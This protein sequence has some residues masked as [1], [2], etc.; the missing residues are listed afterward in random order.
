MTACGRNALHVVATA[1]ASIGDRIRLSPLRA[2]QTE[3]LVDAE[4][5]IL[6]RVAWLPPV[7]EDPEVQTPDVTELVSLDL[8]P[9][10]DPAQFAP[11][12]GSVV[13]ESW[14]E[15]L[16]AGG[17][18]MA[19]AKTTAGL[20]AG[21]LGALIRYW[22]LGRARPDP[23]DPEVAMPTDDPAPEMTAE[24]RPAG[25]E[26]SDEVL[27][28]L[29]DSG[30][31]AFDATLH[32]WYDVPAMLSQVPEPARQTGFGGLGMLLN[33]LTEYGAAAAHSVSALRVG[34]P[35]RYQ[36]DHRHEVKRGP[37]TIACDG[38]RRWRVYDDKMTVGPAEPPPSDI[39][40]VADA[41]WL[42]ECQIAGGALIMAG[43]RPA[44]RMD[45]A[46]GDAPWSFLMMFP[47][48]VAVVDA[49]LGVILSLTSYLGGKA[50]RR[51]ELRDVAATGAEDFRVNVPSDLRTEP[52]T[53]R[54]ASV[55]DAD[56]RH[57]GVTPLKVAGVV[58]REVGKE[59]AKAARSF[60]RR[61]GPP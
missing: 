19:V 56:P 26:V 21:G 33:A 57:Q 24:G 36:I 38:Q 52:E 8:D 46:R 11:P 28:V 37:K 29:H 15:S 13:G 22:P 5:G 31:S 40:D 58:A 61:L 10:I 59:A 60:L 14:S 23:G 27:Q 41:S 44:Y 43:D 6:L 48:A 32:E 53:D 1:R 9:V 30:T 45:V 55:R 4:L 16:S 49:E 50:V 20:A 25:P 51:Y 42:L 3:A 54:W 34:G 18:V 47:A 35:G 12:P 2:G 17:P 39:A 7:D